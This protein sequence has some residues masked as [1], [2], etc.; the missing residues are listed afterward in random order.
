MRIMSGVNEQRH[1]GGLARTDAFLNLQRLM[2]HGIQNLTCQIPV[3]TVATMSI[4]SQVC[5]KIKLTF[6]SLYGSESMSVVY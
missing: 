1:V 6:K 3:L 5:K 2:M 4:N